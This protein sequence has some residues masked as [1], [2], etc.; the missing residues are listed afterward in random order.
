LEKRWEEAK[1]AIAE[2]YKKQRHPFYT[3]DQALLYDRRGMP[4]ERDSMLSGVHPSPKK[5]DSYDTYTGEE[6]AALAKII[7]ADLKKETPAE[8]D[9][10]DVEKRCASSDVT[11]TCNLH[12]LLGVYLKNRGK[13]KLAVEQWKK[14]LANTQ[15]GLD[16]RTCAGAALLEEGVTPEDYENPLLPAKPGEATP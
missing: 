13:P 1:S 14:S 2:S 15:V 7:T 10:A 8:F 9:V 5:Q 11:G 4:A 12:Y 6:M 16:T 3:L